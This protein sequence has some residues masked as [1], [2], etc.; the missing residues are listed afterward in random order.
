MPQLP[1]RHQQIITM[2]AEFIC[3]VVAS[4]GNIE[5]KPQLDAM[6]NHAAKN[7]WANL[8]NAIKQ[9]ATGTRDISLLKSLDEEDAIVAEAILRG[10]QNPETLPDP[11]A[12]PDSTLAAPGLA[13]MIHAASTGNPEALV[14]ISNMAEQ[15]SKA[16]EDMARLAAVIKPLIDGERDPNKLCE[17]MDAATEQLT[18][19]RLEEL[20]KLAIH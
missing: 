9:I 12:K 17:K 7:G 5:L 15:M 2:H 3:Q 18:L 8:A 16:G 4:I 14:L 10:L 11:T 1:E 6:L 19:G 13:H 20:G